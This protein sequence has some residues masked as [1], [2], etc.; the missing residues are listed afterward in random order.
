MDSIFDAYVD[1]KGTNALKY[2]FFDKYHI[3]SDAMPMWV[4]DMDF[5][6]PQAAIDA[7]TRISLHGVFGYTDSRESYD[8]ALCEWFR[9]NFGWNPQPAWNIKTPGIVFAIA[10]AI[11]ALTQPGEAV[12]IQEPVY[13][14]FARMIEAN[15]RRSVVNELRLTEGRYEIDFDDFEACVK[16]RQIKLF[17]LCSPHNPVGRVWTREELSRVGEI[18]L[19]YGVY[20]LSDEIHSDFVFPGQTHT[21]FTQIA[22]SLAPISIICTSPTK[23]FNL[24]GL[25][26][27]NIFIPYPDLRKTFAHA[28]ERTGYSQLNTMGLAAAEAVYTHGQDWRDRLIRY[29]EGNV[30][31]LR[32]SLS[33]TPIRLIEPEGTY[34]MWLDCRALNLNDTELNQF[35]LNKAKLWLNRGPTFGQGGAGFMRMNIGCPRKTLEQAVNRLNQAFG[36]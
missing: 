15:G 20:V 8:A 23:T 28:Y 27:S 14:P 33:Q 9:H 12:L 31:Y 21:V 18:C 26:I 13:Y 19:K 35:F 32:R 25:Q 22:P 5:K 24:A 7:L 36:E 30:A 16:T 2:D 11:T 4:A 17:L 6:A 10:T 34:L 1:R 3:P 29:L